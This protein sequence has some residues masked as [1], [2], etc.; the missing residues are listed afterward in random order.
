MAYQVLSGRFVGRT[1]EL[2]WLRGLL[3]R[4][5]AGEPLVATDPAGHRPGR[6]NRSRGSSWVRSG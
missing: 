6:S 3:A 5:A 4:A 2:A 1:E